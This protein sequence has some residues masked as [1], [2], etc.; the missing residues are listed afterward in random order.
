MEESNSHE[1]SNNKYF[2]SG[3][4]IAVL[5][6]YGASVYSYFLPAESSAEVAA[7]SIDFQQTVDLTQTLTASTRDVGTLFQP[8]NDDSS[9]Y[10]PGALCTLTDSNLTPAGT[11]EMVPQ[12]CE[13]LLEKGQ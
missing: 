11:L 2:S 13:F 10:V 1:S 7:R 4:I 9:V 3:L 8:I 6:M 5:F 12:E